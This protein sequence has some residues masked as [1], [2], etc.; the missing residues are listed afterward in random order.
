MYEVIYFLL[1]IFYKYCTV[2]ITSPM[3]KIYS[4]SF[5]SRRIVHLNSSESILRHKIKSPPCKIIE[6]LEGFPPS[7]MRRSRRGLT[8]L[9]ACVLDAESPSSRWLRTSGAG[10]LL[11][12]LFLA[13]ASPAESAWL[14]S[15]SA[16]VASLP[17]WLPKSLSPGSGRELQRL[18]YLGAF[19]SFSVFAEDDVSTM[20]TCTFLLLCSDS[21]PNIR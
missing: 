7:Q 13:A 21:F 20:A 19:F 9:W 8:R 15:A 2:K 10:W 12:T 17:L 4:T 16:Q 6:E 1:W 3:G 11:R 14:A 5:D 18:S